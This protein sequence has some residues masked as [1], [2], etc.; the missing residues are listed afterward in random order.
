MS[1]KNINKITRIK[2]IFIILIFIFLSIL[3]LLSNVFFTI[4]DK[5][6]L[7]NLESSK[8]ELAIRGNILSEDNF[9]IASSIKLYKATIDTRFLD[10]KKIDLFVKLFSIYSDIPEAKIYEKITDSLKNPGSIVLSYNI[11]SKTA[12]NLKEL[13]FKLRHLN[14]FKSI[15]V[16][17][18]KILR[19]LNINESG[20]KRLYSYEDT[21]TP[22]VGYI[23]KYESDNG[24]TK[25]NGIKGLEKS[26]NNVLNNTKDGKLEGTRDVLSY[27]SFNKN[28]IVQNR[29]DGADLILNIP[30]RLQKNLELMLDKFKT[31][32][33]ADEIIVSVMESSTGKIKALAS[34]NRFNPG[35]I[36]QTDIPYLD[37]SAIE[38]L[39]EPGSI[40]KPI[41][42]SLVM[43][44]NRIKKNEL[45]NAYNNGK[46]NSK[47]EYPRG[48]Y[49]LGRFTIGDDHE[50]TK[51]YLT[52]DD[53]FI[54]SSNIGTLQLAQRLSGKEMYQ[55]L[56]SF[57]ITEKTQIDLPYEK[58]GVMPTIRQFSAGEDKGEDNVFK[59]TISYG[60]GM[61]ATFMQMLKAYSAFN[62]D[63]VIV[64]P[65]IVQSLSVNDKKVSLADDTKKRVIS[66]KTA[67]EIKRL[68]IKTISQGT[69]V[70]AQIDGIEVGGKTGTAQIARHGKYQNIYISSFFGFANEKNKK[71]TIG[72]TVINPISTGKYWYYH[73]ASWSAV[74]VFKE[75]VNNLVKLGYLNKS[76]DN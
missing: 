75:V 55:G 42:I 20:E 4:T 24:K 66:K 63:G 47:G 25:V 10:I 57:G 58:V 14:V 27:I 67:H 6:R 38:F 48:K 29:V 53:I 37:V 19:G 45:F 56:K 73:Y 49:K 3:L 23:R 60:Q 30:L 31:K 13:G 26:Y 35:L 59:A 54:Y 1:S 72:V 46:V 2:K 62:N 76:T 15:E 50:F 71:Y 21:L 16:N 8:T 61:T 70:N 74:P 34:S 11:D 51:H 22:V 17:D 36:R 64:T 28:S 52:V 41:S 9:K 18:N 43:D 65:K 32:L 40:I 5:R 12:K 68:L 7:P 33:S 69:G 39:F 44:K